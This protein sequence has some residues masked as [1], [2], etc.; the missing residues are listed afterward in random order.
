MPFVVRK[1]PPWFLFVLLIPI[2]NIFADVLT[3]YF[4]SATFNPG[5][6][7]AFLLLLFISYFL[8]KQYIFDSLSKYIIIYLAYLFVLTF[9]SSDIMFSMTIFIKVS[10]ASLL[11]PIGYY[12]FDDLAKFRK[13]NISYIYAI[14]IIILSLLISN[15]FSL[16]SSDYSEGSFYFGSAKVNITKTLASLIICSPIMFIFIKKNI[17]KRIL[18]F[19]LAVG[20]I[21]VFIGVKRS[22]LGALVIGIL[23]YLIF[24]PRKSRLIKY[25]T[26]A[27]VFV[28]MTAPFY[29]PIIEQRFEARENRLQFESETLYGEGRYYEVFM[30]FNA[31]YRD[32]LIHKLFGSEL[33]NDRKY[34]NVNRMLHTDYMTLLNGSGIIGLLLFMGIYWQL[35]REK[36]KYL[37]RIKNIELFSEFNS[38]F[39]SIIVAMIILSVAGTIHQIGSR[40]FMFMYLGAMIR[41]MRESGS[42]NNSN[43]I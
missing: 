31:M 8:L 6:I 34:F 38:V 2:I 14:V 27:T 25:L 40:G 24:T 13:L 10:I 12:Y 9:F 20:V 7:R 33:F 30:V 23:I 16:G 36:N 42:I 21:L 19:I 1:A 5:S 32:D 35:F 43:R 18:A 26:Y 22:A 28:L 11:F 37:K 4:E 39:I 15:Y 3:N 17:N 41:L 29:L